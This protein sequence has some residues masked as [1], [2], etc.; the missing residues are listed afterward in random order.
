MAHFAAGGGSPAG[1]SP[2]WPRRRCLGLAFAAII[3]A[4]AGIAK[5]EALAPPTMP[6][7]LVIKGHAGLS[8]IGS[9]A[10]L[11]QIL[12]AE[13]GVAR[14]KTYTPWTDGEPLFEGV[15]LRTLIDRLD[16]HGT[17]IRAHALNDYFVDIPVSDA[18]D[19]DVLVAWSADGNKFTRRDRGPLWVIY[20]WSDHQ[21]LDNRKFSQRSIWQL[22]EMEF[23]E[24]E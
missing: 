16:A 20:P 2:D 12:L 9:E 1:I 11:D 4:G 19:Y 7:L 15:M 10:H 24:I 18:R 5:A 8:N 21:E 3:G 13:M 17:T 6:A 22:Y 14:L 23:R